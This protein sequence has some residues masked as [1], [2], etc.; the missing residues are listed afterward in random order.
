MRNLALALAASLFTGAALPQA[1]AA[2]QSLPSYAQPA[3]PAVSGGS[4]QARESQETI[5]GRVSLVQ[6]EYLE[7]NDDRGFVDRVDFTTDTV[8]RPNGAKLSPGMHVSIRG[9]NE[10]QIFDAYEID[11]ADAAPA[12]GGNSAPS[13]GYNGQA[14]APEPMV[15]Q[16]PPPPPAPDSAPMQQP[17]PPYATPL[18]SQSQ[19][20][21]Q[22]PY[23][24]VYAQPVYVPYAVPYP[25]YAYP[26]PPPYAYYPRFYMR[27]GVRVR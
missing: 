11:A 25:V 2:Q 9:Y 21:G 22:G 6:G 3:Q 26:V 27:F 20:Y 16:A 5:S 12:Y 8:F 4:S 14:S 17:L 18:S 7:V 19:V 13:Y 23:A 24:P 15:A 1:A 10:G